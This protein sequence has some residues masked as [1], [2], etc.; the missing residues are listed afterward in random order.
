M[1]EL[2]AIYVLIRGILDLTELIAAIVVMMEHAMIM[3]LYIQISL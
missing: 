3:V 1:E 2:L